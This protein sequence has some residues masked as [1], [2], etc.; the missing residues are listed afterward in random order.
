MSAGMA[1]HSSCFTSKALSILPH[2]INT[3]P[4]GEVC[5][6]PASGSLARDTC[7]IPLCVQAAEGEEQGNTEEL[8][9]SSI[10]DG[11][12]CDMKEDM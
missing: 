10:H 1:L 9:I 7:G 6:L 4:R 12:E 5:A 11:C 8:Y 2:M 3:E